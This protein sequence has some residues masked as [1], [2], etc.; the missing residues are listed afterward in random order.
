MNC[1]VEVEGARREPAPGKS[2]AYTT[3]DTPL[4]GVSS[5]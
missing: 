4:Q 5:R 3:Q 1:P 2:M